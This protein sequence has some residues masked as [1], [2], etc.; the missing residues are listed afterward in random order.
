MD[1]SPL[2]ALLLGLVVA[3]SVAT[4]QPADPNLG[5]EPAPQPKPGYERIVAEQSRRAHAQPVRL[6]FVGDSTTA[7]WMRAGPEAWANHRVVWDRWYGDRQAFD[8]GVNGDETQNVLWRLAQGEVDGLHPRLIVL[9]IGTNNIGNHQTPMQTE[10]GVAAVI[11]DLHARLPDAHLLL[12]GILPHTP[13]TRNAAC[14]QVNAWLAGQA[15]RWPFVTYLD[16][17]GVLLK[18]GVPDPSLYMESEKPDYRRLLHPNAFG[19]ERLARAME[20]EI[21]HWLGDRS[22]LSAAAN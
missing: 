11:G 17:G 14:M 8:L 12:L 18:N 3:T 1:R 16:V 21:S 4:A 22:K 13:A 7:I 15:A 5:A 6:L 2:V 20:P 10:V 19:A 9:L